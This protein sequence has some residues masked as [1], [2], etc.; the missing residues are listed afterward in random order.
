MIRE[1]DFGVCVTEYF[2][3]YLAGVRN[4]SGNTIKSYRDTFCL[5]LQFLYETM[6]LKPE[7]VKLLNITDETV[8]NFLEWLE[9]ERDNS[10][11]TRNLRLAAIQAFYRYVLMQ[12][13][14]I[15]SYNV[16]YTKLLRNY[17]FFVL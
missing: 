13:P 15:T 2:T 14:R 5:L 10:V 4:L 6:K 9:S 7:K 17:Y 16:C 12:N 11:S 1:T 3:K 8:K